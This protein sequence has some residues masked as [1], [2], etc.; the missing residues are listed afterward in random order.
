MVYLFA[1]PLLLGAVP[2][3][4]AWLVPRLDAGGPWQHT[5]HAFAVATL[6]TGSALQGIMEIYGTTSAYVAYYMWTGLALLALS[7]LLWSIGFQRR[8]R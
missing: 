7:G 2:G 5:V 8:A 4:V 3:L 1:I 6:T